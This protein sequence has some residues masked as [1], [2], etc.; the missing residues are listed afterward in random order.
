VYSAPGA[1]GDF[2]VF[3]F[4]FTPPASAVAFASLTAKLDIA[5]G[6]AANDDRFDINATFALGTTSNGINPL[7]EAVTVQIGPLSMTIPAGSFTR[8]RFGRFKFCGVVGGVALDVLIRP[9]ASGQFLRTAEGSGAELST[10]T[11]PVTVALQIGDDRGT[12]TV[13]AD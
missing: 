4:T 1:H 10:T 7:T 9:A 8:D 2:D 3:A 5:R 11:N 6:P 13:Q 12:T